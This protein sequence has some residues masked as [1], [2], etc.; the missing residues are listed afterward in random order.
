MVPNSLG[1][2]ELLLQFGTKEQRD[3]WLPRLADGREIPCFGLTSPEAG[4]DAASMI[5]N[6]V[7]TRG[8]FRGRE[9]LGIRLNW[10][11]RYI[12]LGPIAT[13]LGLAFKLHDPD[14]LI[15][16]ED[17]V[18]ITVALVPTNLPGIKIGRRHLPAMQVFQNGPN[19]GHNV[20]IPLDHIIGGVEQA[21]KGW[22]MLMSALAA[23][24]GISLPSLSAAGAAYTAHTTGAYARIREQFH[25]PI[26]KFEAIQE[27]LG[28]M[29]AAA[30]LLDAARRHTCA[31]DRSGPSPGGGHGDHEGPGDRAAAH[32]G[33]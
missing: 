26:G 30:Y 11:K 5:D 2:G 9:V 23:G 33:Q 31:G 7:V 24:R 12:T 20:F 15:G 18:G 10:H 27:R 21:G 25:L 14:H 1:P 6:G 3:Y 29:A 13:V 32:L 8:T 16:Q 4:S 28:R 19:E 22:K 17:D